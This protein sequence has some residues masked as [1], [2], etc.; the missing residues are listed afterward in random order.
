MR[1]G[2]RHG[3]M[4]RCGTRWKQKQSL[5]RQVH[6]LNQLLSAISH[7]LN[8]RG[9]IDSPNH[10]IKHCRIQTQSCY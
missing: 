7:E 6:C 10:P 5:T 2:D 9:V 3:T 1:G 8:A 4:D